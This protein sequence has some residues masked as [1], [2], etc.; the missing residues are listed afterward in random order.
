MERLVPPNVAS[1]AEYARLIPVA[2]GR[3]AFLLFFIGLVWIAPAWRD[4][5]FLYGLAIW[6]AAVLVVWA[7]DLCRMAKPRDL[8]VERI[9]SEPL[10]LSTRGTIKLELRNSSRSPIAAQVWD[11]TPETLCRELPSLHLS[12]PAQGAA[13]ASYSIEP[14]ARG[15]AVFGDVWLRYQSPLM[16][17]E[18]WARARLSQT[19]RV[20]PNLDETQR[21][22]I[23]LIRSRQIELEKRL[24]RQR[25][26][27]REFESLRDYREGDEF[28][29]ISWSATARRGKL[30]TKV[31]Q[32]ERSQ[33]VWLVLDAGRLLR[34]QVAGL[35]KLD[36][37]V[38][39]ALCLAQVAF[40]SGDRVAL[41]AYGRKPQQRVGPG[42]GIP[43][44]RA[45]IESMSQIHAEPYEADHLY[46]AEHLLSLQ[47]RRSL[48]VWLTDL[49]ETAATPEV[50]EC[51]AKMAARHLVLL[52]V[53][54]QPEL[55]NLVAVAPKSAADMYHYTAALEIVQRRGILLRRVRQQGALTL[56][57]DPRGLSTA[58]VNRYLEVKERS[59][60]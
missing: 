33:V 34:T 51:A 37:T 46:A 4:P 10:G 57:V 39:A 43:Q 9:W 53:M 3:R 6:D 15:D 60:L 38:N 55:R 28:R 18:R 17:G 11:E 7:W 12:A 23:Y 16:I 8:A 49:A 22:R 26:Q 25:G 59:L 52:C 29:D 21:M 54:G 40:Y 56:E 36:Y 13:F 44:L 5:R 2:F 30:I 58:L 41:F 19:V 42:R 31:H 24:K 48:I 27:G 32:I 47:S 20:Y 1:H 14:R 35:S 50:I 45:L